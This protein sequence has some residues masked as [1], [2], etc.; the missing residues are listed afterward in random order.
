MRH[1][2]LRHGSPCRQER[3]QDWIATHVVDGTCAH[4]RTFRHTAAGACRPRQDLHMGIYVNTLRASC[5]QRIIDWPHLAWHSRSRRRHAAL[6]RPLQ[7]P[8]WLVLSGRSSR[9]GST[10]SQND[11]VCTSHAHTHLEYINQPHEPAGTAG[12]KQ[13]HKGNN[14]RC[15]V[16]EFAYARCLTQ[17]HTSSTSTSA[18][19]A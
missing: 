12:T 9:T 6:L 10:N 7:T 19:S 1:A 18:A 14:Q 11:A 3:I 2:E 5:K 16:L 15:E 13:R 4:Q 17:V 8:E